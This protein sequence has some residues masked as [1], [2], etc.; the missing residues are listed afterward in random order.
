LL[1]A[2]HACGR[3]ARLYGSPGGWIAAAVG[4]L[5]S[6]HVASRKPV[7]AHDQLWLVVQGTLENADAEAAALNAA[8][9]L[10]PGAV[11][12]ARVSID[13]SYEPRVIA[14]D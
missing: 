4:Y 9:D 2:E 13:Q 7:L 8:H 11:I 10:Q 5:D 6:T 14:V 3:D 12:V 1:T